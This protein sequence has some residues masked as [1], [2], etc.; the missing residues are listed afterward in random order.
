[1]YFNRTPYLNLYDG[2]MRG[3]RSAGIG[4]LDWRSAQVFCWVA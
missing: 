4:Y 2:F 1:M 3:R